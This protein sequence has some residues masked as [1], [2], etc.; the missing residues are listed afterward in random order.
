MTQ[1]VQQR[2]GET[3]HFPF[4]SDRLF[5]SGDAWYFLIRGDNSKGPFSSA[6]EAKTALDRYIN[7]LSILHKATKIDHRHN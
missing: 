7:T 5:F 1:V 6:N 4:R 2:A 3:G